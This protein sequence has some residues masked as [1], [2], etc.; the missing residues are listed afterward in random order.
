LG[1]A[2]IIVIDV[3]EHLWEGIELGDE[4]TDVG[5]GVGRVAPGAHI[6]AENAVGAVEFAAL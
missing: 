3:Y 1:I 6:A 4:L 2:I 5:W